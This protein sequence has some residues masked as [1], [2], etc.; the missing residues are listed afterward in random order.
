MVGFRGSS[1]S[2]NPT[3]TDDTERWQF[4]YEMLKDFHSGMVVPIKKFAYSENGLATVPL[5]R[6]QWIKSTLG[7]ELPPNSGILFLDFPQ[8]R[9][10]D[11]LI[12]NR[13]MG[14]GN[15]GRTLWKLIWAV[16]RNT[17]MT[18]RLTGKGI[19]EKAVNTTI[20]GYLRCITTC[21]IELRTPLTE[22]ATWVAMTLIDEY[23]DRTVEELKKTTANGLHFKK[24]RVVD[25]DLR[26]LAKDILVSHGIKEFRWRDSQLMEID[27]LLEDPKFAKVEKQGFKKKLI[28]WLRVNGWLRPIHGGH[29]NRAFEIKRKVA[30]KIA[31]S[32]SELKF[33]KRHPELFQA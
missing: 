27:E 14:C 15:D 22:M 2:E 17:L 30:N 4:A 29:E 19:K 31:L 13:M 8:Y 11:R 32:S 5:N 10:K 24:S 23:S 25:L 7:M 12:H 6:K 21:P 1:F 18:H 28:E 26:K 3:V 9:A 33:R 20:W 16:V